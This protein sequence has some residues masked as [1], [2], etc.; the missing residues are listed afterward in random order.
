MHDQARPPKTPRRGQIH[1][2]SQGPSGHRQTPSRQRATPRRQ[3][4]M[5]RHQ[6][7]QPQPSKPNTWASRLYMYTNLAAGRSHSTTGTWTLEDE[8]EAYLLDSQAADSSIGYW[9]VR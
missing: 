1:D 5:P 7:T 3:T 6:P 8:I 2:P 4:Q 9:Q